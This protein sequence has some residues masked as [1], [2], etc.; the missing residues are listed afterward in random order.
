[1][2]L[3]SADYNI[4]KFVAGKDR[5]RVAPLN[6][7]PTPWPFEQAQAKA[8][9]KANAIL[10]NIKDDVHKICSGA[11]IDA[12]YI[13]MQ[14]IWRKNVPQGAKDC[15]LV[16]TL[17]DD[18]ARW[19]VAATSIK[20]LL[21]KTSF[22]ED[23]CIVEI[24]N[25]RKMYSDISFP[26]S[27]D[28]QLL[29]CIREVQPKIRSIIDTRATD[30]W[31]SIAYH[32]RKSKFDKSAA[33]HCVIIYVRPGSS[34][35]FEMIEQL[36]VAA[37][38]S[39]QFPTV[40]LSVEILP[41]MVITSAEGDP[42]YTRCMFTSDTPKNGDS[43][44]VKGVKPDSGTLGGWVILTHKTDGQ[45]INGIMTPYHVIAKVGS[46]D[47]AEN[48][49]EGIGFKGKKYCPKGAI[50]WPSEYD[51]DGTIEYCQESVRRGGDANSVAKSKKVLEILTSLKKSDGL[52]QVRFASGNTRSDKNQVM[53]WAI[54]QC[55]KF[56]KNRPPIGPINQSQIPER[57]PELLYERNEHSCVKS[58]GPELVAGDWVLKRGRTTENT[59]GE[60]NAVSRE[61]KWEQKGKAVSYELDIV[62][63]GGDFGDRGDSGSW[64][65]NSKFELVGML[66]A[67]DSGASGNHGI[68]T[69]IGSLLKDIEA[70]TGYRLSLP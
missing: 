34:A 50:V 59:H 63:I 11:G 24:R 69:P 42:R 51:S 40:A 5:F 2:V 12:T 49:L 58:F 43:I 61:V 39:A 3:G 23:E 10:Q 46:G 44:G 20:T 32:D 29:A 9:E 25:H 41:G 21:A 70:R 19:L 17:D 8:S 7:I 55:K 45:V 67:M 68:V 47:R 64:V 52:G 37:V 15:L 35:M 31:T 54:I 1:L 53:D 56:Q 14:K 66:I 28:A 22:E 26:I 16:E 48:D 36:C 4:E 38:K 33:K 62:G 30:I 18:P 65:I 60:V 6:E 57:I 13:T 27:N